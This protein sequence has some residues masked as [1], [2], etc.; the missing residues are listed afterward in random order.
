M[1]HNALLGNSG[2]KPTIPFNG[3]EYKVSYLTYRIRSK[4]AERYRSQLRTQLLED[5]DLYTD[6][7]WEAAL[8]KL[9]DDRVNGLQN[10]ESEPCQKW[11]QTHAGVVAMLC[12]MLEPD[13]PDAT[14]DLAESML[15]HAPKQVQMAVQAVADALPK[16]A[17][18][19]EPPAPKAAT[20]R[21]SKR[22][23]SR[24]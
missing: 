20:P 17:V 11:L 15:M 10:F 13:A 18:T 8:K 9:Q 4:V 23:S 22:K 16:P 7:Q 12:C 24:G 3:T 2:T 19:E 6:E 1:D 21:P 5:R 14:D